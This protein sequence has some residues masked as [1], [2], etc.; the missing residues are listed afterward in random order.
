MNSPEKRILMTNNNFETGIRE[1]GFNMLT[2]KLNTLLDS[3]SDEIRA[4]R[5]RLQKSKKHYA[6]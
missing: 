2:E 3:Y 4:S 1:F 5:K 6:V